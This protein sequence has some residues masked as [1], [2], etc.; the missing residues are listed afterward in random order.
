MD[1][2]PIDGNRGLMILVLRAVPLSQETVSLEVACHKGNV[3]EM[4]RWF[5]SLSFNRAARFANDEAVNRAIERNLAGGLLKE[6]DQ[7]KARKMSWED[8][9]RHYRPGEQYD[10]TSNREPSIRANVEKHQDLLR[11]ITGRLRQVLGDLPP[12]PNVLFHSDCFGDLVEWDSDPAVALIGITPE[13]SGAIGQHLSSVGFP[14]RLEDFLMGLSDYESAGKAAVQHIRRLMMRLLEKESF[15]GMTTQAAMGLYF[16]AVDQACVASKKF[17]GTWADAQ[18]QFLHLTMMIPEA[19]HPNGGKLFRSDGKIESSGTLIPS[20]N[21]DSRPLQV[22]MGPYNVGWA[23]SYAEA[24]GA[25]QAL[26]DANER[27]PKR[28]PITV[29]ADMYFELQD[30]RKQLVEQLTPV[31]VE[32]WVADGH[33]GWCPS[34]AANG[35]TC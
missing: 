25:L 5:R 20:E 1:K 24:V 16:Q 14:S 22:N 32:K 3:V 9:L 27:L 28:K 11:H 18:S 7:K 34:G 10:R 33:C 23:R 4:E 17:Q 19:V 21:W 35:S 29:L 13:E 30:Q 31:V 26:T 15:E 6:S 8:V 2:P 12:T